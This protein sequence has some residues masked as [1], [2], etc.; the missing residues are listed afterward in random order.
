MSG[1][2]YPKGSEWRKWD[3]H[4]HTPASALNNHFEGTNEDGKW[5]KYLAKLVSF[6]DISVLGLTDYFS[7]EG[8]KKVKAYKDAGHL[9][10]IDFLLPNVELRILPVTSEDTPINLHIIFSPEIV[11]ELD[12]KF[13]SSLEYSYQEE[14]YKCIRG[15]LIKLGRKYKNDS[16]LQEN[17]AYR[18]GIEQFKSSFDKI[19]EIIT[20]DKLLQ[21]K[22][23][24]VVPNRSGDGA[25]GIQ[26]S[27]LAATRE[28]IYR[29]AH[30][31]FSANPNDRD[32]FLGKGTDSLDEVI[33]KYGSLKPCIH[34][35]DAHSLDKV[36]CP[37]L[38]R[39]TWIKADPT[40]EGLKQIIYEPEDRVYI[41]EEPPN[42]KL[43]R[44]KIIKSITISNSNNWFE[45]DKPMSLNE[46]L[47]SIIGGKGSGKTA[48]LDLIAYST[49]SYK[50]YEKDETK[51]KS[52]LK[53]AFRELTG[54]KIKIEWD[55]GKFD[56]KEIGNKLEEATKEGKVR[57]LP[58]DYVDQLC[59]EIGKNEIERQ[60]ENV[61]FQKILPENK[62]NYS[63]FKS[64][65]DV[66]LKVIND[67]KSRVTKQIQEVNLKI[68]DHK[69]LI[70][71][72]DVK[73]EQIAEIEDEIKKLNAEMDK[74]SEALEDAGDQ[75]GVLSELN[76]SI[77][78][79]T[80]IEK[81]ISELKTK[82]LKVEE[83]INEIYGFLEDSKEFTDK[84]QVDLQIIG[85]K[86][87]DVDQ[88]K[89]ILSPEN[90]QHIIDVRKK[91]IDEEIGRQKS[92][93]E[94]FDKNIKELNG[95]ITLEKSKQDKIKE[96][97]KSLADFK[98]K[99][100]SLTEDIKKAEESEKKLSELLNDRDNLFINFFEL[101]FEEKERLK[102]IYAPL[103]NILSRS[104][105]ENEKL[106]DFTVQFNINFNTMAVEGHNL[107]DLRREGLFHQSKPE[108]L[109]ENIKSILFKPNLDSPKISDSDKNS[110]KDFLKKILDLFE[111]DGR[112]I[113]SQLKQ[114]KYT[115]LD[116][117]KWLYSTK[118][119]DISYSIKFN[120]IDLDNLSPGL[121]GVSL[122]IL[123]LELDEEDRRPI[124]IDQPE[125]NLDNRSVFNTLVR[126]F[127]NAK[128]RRQVIIV[129]HNPNLVANTDSEQIFV[130]NFNRGLEQQSSRINYVSG[131]LENTFPC[132]SKN[133]NILEKQGIRE[134]VC[135]ILEGGKEAFEKREKKYGFKTS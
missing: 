85:V 53:R 131:S 114:D 60:I 64:Y 76:S 24:V 108:A 25:S 83:I 67:K 22:S 89:V 135:E 126:Y 19:K 30:C 3:L 10:N 59:S 123:F 7:I 12:S 44:D 84:L 46:G 92:E 41:G 102:A 58:Q 70:K 33:R 63:D 23:V 17:I 104:S 116:F 73:N 39:F 1:F 47:V 86:K 78:Q 18:D 49:D 115:E 75:K 130:A 52:F 68:F 28:G 103:E 37:D 26:H 57:Y 36:C 91:E 48:I 15:D 21:E 93:L 38:N 82:L 79:K 56:E 42:K 127:R 13:F 51:S 122:L 133:N 74:I 40:F 77:E 6:T 65:R 87:D 50:S 101:I 95:K 14:V 110:I 20:K 4:V 35:S 31:I 80:T 100:D 69:E 81:I 94:K 11:D 72:K 5:D 71:S 117:D 111:K 29:F 43:E 106:F 66:Q 61:I 9:S 90:L 119:F 16:T 54:A 113:A 134:H 62:A 2:K 8:Y 32:Y 125:E 98:K 99:K 124:L 118:Y 34:G 27:S 112:T 55:E 129:T 132:D 120:G 128:E 107:I 88:I 96:I 121:K 45:D 97:N 109:E 105:E